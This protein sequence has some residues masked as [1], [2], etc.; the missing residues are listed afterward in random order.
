MKVAFGVGKNPAETVVEPYGAVFF[1][2]ESG[3]RLLGL[4]TVPARIDVTIRSS[5]VTPLSVTFQA[6]GRD[7]STG[8]GNMSN[9]VRRVIE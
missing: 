2:M 7:R 1:D 4:G 3:F 5:V 9:P 6:R 8:F